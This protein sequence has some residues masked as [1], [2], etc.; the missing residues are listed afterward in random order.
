MRVLKVSIIMIDKRPIEMIIVVGCLKQETKD[1]EWVALV[2][3]MDR[4]S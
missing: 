3:N 1:G 2:I 4:S